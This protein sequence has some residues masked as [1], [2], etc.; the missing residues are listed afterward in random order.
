MVKSARYINVL[1][2]DCP[3]CA[4]K[5]CPRYDEKERPYAIEYSAFRGQIFSIAVLPNFLR[6][7]L[8]GPLAG[9]LPFC[10]RCDDPIKGGLRWF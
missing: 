2:Q 4:E 1:I 10:P 7:C 3:R 9:F 6:V 5:K 8:I